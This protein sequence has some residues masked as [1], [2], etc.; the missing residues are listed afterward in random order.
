MEKTV[1]EPLSRERIELAA[2][3]LIEADGLQAFS[4][5]KLAAVLRC[6]AMSIY[7]YFP[8]K[9]HLM[10]AL[11]DHV[12]AEMPAIPGP[13]LPWI[14]R[15]RRNGRE[16]R[17]VAVRRP[18]LFIFVATHRMNT[19]KAL[20]W[21]DANIALFEESGLPHEL[22][23]RLFRSSSYYIMGAGL[24]ETAGYSRGPSTVT[25]TSPEVMDR[26]YASVAAAGAYFKSS[27]FE[28]TFELGWEMMLAG[29]EALLERHRNEQPDAISAAA[30]SRNA[31]RTRSSP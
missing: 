20:G 23:V 26:D 14:E 17:R 15:V 30:S 3:D 5:R 6:E 18:N 7:Y 11:I 29:F 24:D 4:I 10:D 27:D 9:G 28:S 16:V 31:R 22:A 8:S 19:P 13:E 2:L 25:P 12:V 1:R 21:L